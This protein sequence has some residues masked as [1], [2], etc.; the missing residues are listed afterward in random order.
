MFR[1]LVLLWVFVSTLLAGGSARA[2]MPFPVDLVPNRT[3][4]ER[5]GLE[6]Q[7]FGVIPLNATERLMK[8]TLTGDLI[9]AQTDYAFLHAFDAESGRFLWSAS[10][11]ESEPG[12]PAASRPI[13]TPFSRPTPTSCTRSTRRRAGRSGSTTWTRSPPVHRRAMKTSP[14]S[15]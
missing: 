12:S 3:A 9:F 14:W 5:L 15:A 2:Q 11:W 1:R 6:R 8:I 4:L 13:P 7:W 10:T